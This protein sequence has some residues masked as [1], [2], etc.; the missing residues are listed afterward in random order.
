MNTV[1]KVTKNAGVLLLAKVISRV[2]AFFYIMY[3]ARY[4]GAERFGVL[5]F[6]LAFTGISGVLMDLGLDQLTIREVA[7]NQSLAGMYVTNVTLMK[8]A[9]VIA[10]FGVIAIVVHVFHYPRQTVLVVCVMALYMGFE[11]FNRFFYA[12]FQAFE[13]MEYASLGQ[14]LEGLIIFWGILL[15]IRNDLGVLGIAGMFLA[16][17]GIALAVIFMILRWKFPEV[18]KSAGKADWDFWASTL[19]KALPFGLSAIFVTV[20]FWV[21]TVML[22][23]M[24]GSEMVGWYN[25]AYRLIFG[26]MLIPSVFVAAIF[27]VMSRHYKTAK[28]LLRIEYEIVFRYL[29]AAALFIFAFGL[30]FAKEIIT[31]IYGVAYLPSVIALEVL[32]WV[33][34]IIFMTFLFGNFLAAV[35]RQKVVTMVAGAN[36]G[37]NVILNLLLIPKYGYIGASVA[38]VLTET[39][40]LIL[41]GVYIT[42]HFLVIPV[43]RDVAKPLCCI[44]LTAVAL[45]FMRQWAHWVTAGVVGLLAY[46]LLL[47]AFQVISRGDLKL[48]KKEILGM[49]GTVV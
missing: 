1:Q 35:D 3:A 13:R 40:G 47:F 23:L 46:M 32:I 34:P 10:T 19:R 33:I 48:V 16:G 26:L 30:L 17:G 12:V 5:S 41:M 9:L 29:F 49:S 21:D 38:T 31:V 36:A 25:A 8:V 4:L 11:V 44:A 42:R 20:Y 45:F 24:K 14:V 6:A 15:A 7:R 2:L 43:I 39:L 27:P 22:S 37:L 28:A 18:K